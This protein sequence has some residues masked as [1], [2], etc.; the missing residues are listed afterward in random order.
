M[1]SQKQLC[2]KPVPGRCLDAIG[3]EPGATVAHSD[4]QS[5][6]PV[7]QVLSD[8]LGW[9]M[10]VLLI[11]AAFGL[12]VRRRSRQELA[13][14]S[15]RIPHPG[16]S[17]APTG[18]STASGSTQG[19]VSQAGP[20]RSP[21]GSGAPSNDGALSAPARPPELTGARHS[22]R[23]FELLAQNVDQSRRL[24]LTEAR[25]DLVLAALPRERW[26]VE[27]YVLRAG[28]RIP[29]LILGETGVF[30]L[31]TLFGPP[32]WSDLPL[33]NRVAMDIKD[34]LPGYPGPVRAGMCRA[35]EP[36]I[37][38]RWW[39]RAETRG[40]CWVMGLDWVI[41]WLEHFG[42]GH[43]LG[44]D[45]VARLN[46]LAGPHWGHPIAPMPPGIPD[47]APWPPQG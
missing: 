4:P 23:T 35:L 18:S 38:P 16:S 12:H 36:S 9:G 10:L 41:P 42:S 8:V 31:W 32:Q 17:F 44:V 7:N 33:V 39:Y 15:R 24:A 6:A 22:R 14:A 1:P 46:A 20:A 11:A 5:P 21:H 43:G 13:Q 27:R 28:H 3:A 30:T 26:L 34:R 29:F 40:G 19:P 45:D 25:L 47:V 37:A 2:T